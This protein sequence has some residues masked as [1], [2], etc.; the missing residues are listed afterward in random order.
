MQRLLDLVMAH[1]VLAVL[2]LGVVWNTFVGALDAPTKA[3]SPYY[4]F[5]FKFSNSLAM[6]FQRARS[7]SIE[8]SPNFDDAVKR[9]L[10]QQADPSKVEPP[11]VLA[12]HL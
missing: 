3:S 2:A 11:Q 8:N 5:I 7:T 10:A 12:P 9:Y 6:N 4:V 1:Q